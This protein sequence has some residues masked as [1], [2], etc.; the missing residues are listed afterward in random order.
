[1]GVDYTFKLA[2]GFKTSRKEVI[3]AFKA[4]GA[5]G[6]EEEISDGEVDDYLSGW[7]DATCCCVMHSSYSGDYSDEYFVGLGHKALAKMDYGGMSSHSRASAKGSVSVEALMANKEEIDLLGARL[8]EHGIEISEATI[9]VC[10]SI[11]L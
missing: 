9:L 11:W 6:A 3:A 7:L 4:S 8:R 5:E 10:G 2:I 1:M